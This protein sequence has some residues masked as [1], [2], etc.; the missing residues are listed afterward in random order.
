MSKIEFKR[1]WFVTFFNFYQINKYSISW[2][3]ITFQIWYS[4]DDY[5]M[6]FSKQ[7]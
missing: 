2:E 7:E 3:K 6:E 4:E 1:F 5:W